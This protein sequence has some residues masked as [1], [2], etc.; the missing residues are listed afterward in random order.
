M[1]LPSEYQMNSI[2]DSSQ[3]DMESIISI[4]N[5]KMNDHSISEFVFVSCTVY[6]TLF[7]YITYNY[8]IIVKDLFISKSYYVYQ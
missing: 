6:V 8:C 7:A 1:L 3:R 2:D 4:N 5:S